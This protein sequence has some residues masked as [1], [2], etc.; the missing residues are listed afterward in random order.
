MEHVREE[1][2]TGIAR[3]VHDELGQVLTT[4][5]MELALLGKKLHKEN[6]GYEK[7]T[8]MM[9]ELM[10]N[11][12]QTVKRISSGLRPPILD[13][14]GIV[15][16]LKWQSHEF[17]KRT[18]IR[19]EF[20]SDPPEIHLESKLATT[21]FRIFQETLTNVVRHAKAKKICVDLKD[22]NGSL[23]LRVRDD[24]KGI[25]K[26]QISD[27]QSLGVLGM[28]ERALVWGGTVQLSSN[29]P[30]GTTVIL[31]IPHEN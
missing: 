10:D 6:L 3:E 15:D 13:V 26:K 31:T 18:G 4:L 24:G 14:C 22:K 29:N 23:T 19:F 8:G 9:L 30:K 27:I 28:R 20:F 5:K 21:V 12:I 16:A 7:Q 2:R 17:L 11:T 1:E 25:T